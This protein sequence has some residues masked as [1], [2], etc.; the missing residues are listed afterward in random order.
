MTSET[1]Q[2]AALAAAGSALKSLVTEPAEEPRSP[3]APPGTKDEQVPLHDYQPNSQCPVSIST[4][5]QFESEGQVY[6]R[7]KKPESAA[8]DTTHSESDSSGAAQAST[9]AKGR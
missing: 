9:A 6:S 7:L 4:N 8:T 1:V 2:S 3:P 5:H